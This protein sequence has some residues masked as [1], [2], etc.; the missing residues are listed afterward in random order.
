MIIS[1][2][3][4]F[5]FIKTRKTAGTAIE[6][7]LAPSLIAGDYISP[8]K[9]HDDST[10]RLARIFTRELRKRI[11]DVKPRNPHLPI[12]IIDNY[13]ADEAKGYF[14]FSV[15]RNPWDKAVSAFFWLSHRRGTFRGST[16]RDQFQRF[17]AGSRLSTFSDFD[18]YST[19]GK[20]S[21]DAV[22]QYDQLHQSLCELGNKGLIPFVDIRN[23]RMKS[24]Q[25]PVHAHKLEDFYGEAFD[26]EASLRV[27]ENFSR[28]I[29]Y[30]GYRPPAAL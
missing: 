11:K 22:L 8:L 14:R 27:Y 13:F 25:R 19:D 10:N 29:A 26:N 6:V 21:V 15:E 4:R 5:C 2:Y 23:T 18:M 30:F 17:T 12:S 9:E 1:H 16:L 20:I 7:A 28:E 3:H 24:N